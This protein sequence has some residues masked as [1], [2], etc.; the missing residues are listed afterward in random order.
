[1]GG[2][3]ERGGGEEEGTGTK[4]GEGERKGACKTVIFWFFHS[5]SFTYTRTTTTKNK[6]LKK[7]VENLLDLT[8][9]PQC[10]CLSPPRDSGHGPQKATDSAQWGFADPPPL[11]ASPPPPPPTTGHGPQKATD[12]AQWGFA[13]PPPP[14]PRPNNW[15]WAPKGD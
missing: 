14:P 15:T 5:G 2:G 10:V 6:K 9:L 8:D 7:D 12:S 13:D 11:P 3:G 1:M 4:G